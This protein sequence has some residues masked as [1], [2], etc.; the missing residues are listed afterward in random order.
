[1]KKEKHL[2]I[3]IYIC[4][5]SFLLNEFAKVYVSQ[6]NILLIQYIP[7]TLLIISFILHMINLKNE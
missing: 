2:I 1:M 3:A 7:L 6:E 4:T 5:V